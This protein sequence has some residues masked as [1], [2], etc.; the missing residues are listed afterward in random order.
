VIEP[1][2]KAFRTERYARDEKRDAAAFGVSVPHEI[3]QR[4]LAALLRIEDTLVEIRDAL[5]T[6]HLEPAAVL[7]SASLPV[8]LSD[9]SVDALAKAVGKAV[10]KAQKAPAAAE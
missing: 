7:E 2:A 4:Q 8:D 5:R 6:N 10:A 1:E 3:A 9:A